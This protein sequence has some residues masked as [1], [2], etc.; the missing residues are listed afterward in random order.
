[1]MSLSRLKFSI[2]SCS[3]KLCA[4]CSK[5]RARSHS[6]LSMYKSEFSWS[7]NNT[8]GTS[9]MSNS[10]CLLNSVWNSFSLDGEFIFMPRSFS[11]CDASSGSGSNLSK[12]I[13]KNVYKIKEFAISGYAK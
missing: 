3:I 13:F 4:F 10:M 12:N 5:R 2:F 8:T 7:S 11:L 1:M 6:S 9:V